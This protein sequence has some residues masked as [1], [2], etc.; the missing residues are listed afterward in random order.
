M[1]NTTITNFRQNAFA[2]VEAAVKF[3]DVINV[4]TKNGN[5]VLMSEEEYNGLMATL[6]LMR[7]P[8]FVESIKEARKEPIEE[9]AVYEPGEEW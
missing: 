4:T 7:E 3:N 9:C 6:E 1:T 5:A 8:G 2:Y